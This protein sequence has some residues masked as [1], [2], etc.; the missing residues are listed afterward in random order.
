MSVNLGDRVKDKISGMIGI[1]IGRTEW[2]FGCL[3]IVVQAEALHDGKAIDP[4]TFDEPQLE[5]LQRGVLAVEARQKREAPAG[6]R[7]PEVRR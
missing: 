2:M 7:P 3:R 1:A 5:I 4:T 6:P